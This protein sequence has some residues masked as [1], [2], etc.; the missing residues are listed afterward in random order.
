M[1]KQWVE[2]LVSAAL[3]GTMTPDG[4]AALGDVADTEANTNHGTVP[5]VADDATTAGKSHQ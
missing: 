4:L 3:P 1:A 2:V 5:S